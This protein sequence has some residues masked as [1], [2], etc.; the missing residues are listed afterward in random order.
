[1]GLH[2]G[3]VAMVTGSTRGLG[4]SMALRLAQEGASVV[5]M[6]RSIEAAEKAANKIK[7]ETGANVLPVACNVTDREQ[8]AAAVA[9]TVETFGKIDILVNNA[10]ITWD[11][12]FMKMTDEAWQS[13]L[14]A[15]LTSV[16]M[17]TQEVAKYMREAR[18]GRVINITSMTGQ[19]GNFGQANYG[20]AKAGIIGLTKTL[21]IELGRRN[22]S[23]N[24][25]SPGLFDSDM[26]AKMPPEAYQAN[27]DAIPLGRAGQPREVAALVSFLASEDAGF[28]NGAV[29][30]INGGMYR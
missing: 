14:E 30:S 26:T 3:K 9:K 7:E 15:D 29:I 19:M 10:G 8:I 11:A 28:I 24:A 20:A 16:F 12:S 13:V 2:D 6:G 25:V 23:V 17:F 4:N 1:M 22:I 18:W 5:I 27:I 21:A